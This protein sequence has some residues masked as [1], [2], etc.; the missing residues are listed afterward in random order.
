[1]TFSPRSPSST[2]LS[3]PSGQLIER[4]LY[5]PRQLSSSR[6]VL[7]IGTRNTCR[8]FEG[9]FH[10]RKILG[11]RHLGGPARTLEPR[12]DLS[13][14]ERTEPGEQGSFASVGV[15]LADGTDQGCL[16]DLLGALVIA[17]EPDT[18]GRAS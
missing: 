4:E 15:E 6:F 8:R 18:Y 10:C 3:V 7:G 12:A 11:E 5:E 9:H 13:P 17:A 16:H 1:M 2:H 14:T